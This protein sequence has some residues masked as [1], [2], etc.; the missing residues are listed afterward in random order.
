MVEACD[1]LDADPSIGVV[2]L[3]G[4]NNTFCSGADRGVLARLGQ[5][6]S[7]KAYDCLDTLYSAFAR[8]GRLSMPTIACIEG[9]AVGAGLNLALAAD[10]RL[11]TTDAVLVSGFAPNGIHPGGGHLYLLTRAAGRE[12]AAAL[13]L[14]GQR[15]T[16]EEAQRRGLVWAAVPGAELAAHLA[17]LTATPAA[18]PELARATKNSL[19]LSDGAEQAWAAATEI[20][21]ARQMWS[22]T[23][24]RP[25]TVKRI[26]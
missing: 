19:R 22:L 25:E 16:G 12:S 26:R 5:T 7:H 9:A 8:F 20:E 14:L 21:R 1:E 13:G 4:A 17:E 10:V 18:D 6:T 11:A 23:R 24:P 3:R 2:V 15:L